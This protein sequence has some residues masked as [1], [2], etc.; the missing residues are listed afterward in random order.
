MRVKHLSQNFFN[1]I[2]SNVTLFK[3]T[4]KKFIKHAMTDM[5]DNSNERTINKKTFLRV[6]H[7]IESFAR[8]N[9][10]DL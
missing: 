3:N 5:L 7:H 4:K 1:V 2:S 6:Q 8:V 10:F 9:S